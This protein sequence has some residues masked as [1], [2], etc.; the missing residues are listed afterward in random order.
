MSMKALSGACEFQNGPELYPVGCSDPV[1][2]TKFELVWNFAGDTCN[3]T[4]G[5]S[6]YPY[7]I[8]KAG[9]ARRLAVSLPPRAEVS[10]LSKCANPECDARFRYLRSGKLFQFEVTT[11]PETANVKNILGVRT[12]P[13]KPSR[14]VEH[15]WLCGECAESMTLKNEK[16]HS[17]VAIPLC[18]Q[19]H[20]A[21]A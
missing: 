6:I 11:V 16:N 8:L 5:A 3:V 1:L 18:K 4:H 13:K 9:A 17:V 21:T 19:A 2:S 10:V 15:F 20:R 7:E 14:K 12:P